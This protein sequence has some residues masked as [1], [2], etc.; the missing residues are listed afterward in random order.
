MKKLY[1]IALIIIIAFAESSCSKYEDGP[2]ISLRSKKNRLL[3]E[4][5]V[6]EFKKNNDDLTQFY[7]DTCGCT[8]KFLYDEVVTQGVKNNYFK[9]ECPLNSWNYFNP[10]PDINFFHYFMSS[11]SFSENNES[12]WLHIGMNND[13][14]YKWGVYPLTICRECFNPLYI[15]KL[16]NNELWARYDDIDNVYTIKFEKK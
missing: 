5:E 14:R 13:T 16:T 1:F 9:I 4:W 6:V 2:L 8:F 11:W 7:L 15:L 12:I 10:D 3:G